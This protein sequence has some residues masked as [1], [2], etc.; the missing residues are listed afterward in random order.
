[1]WIDP[2][3]GAVHGSASLPYRAGRVVAVDSAGT[4]I[5]CGTRQGIA[6][7]AGL[8]P[9]AP[10]PNWRVELGSFIPVGAALAEGVLYVAGSDG[11][12]HVIAESR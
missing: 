8:R 9:G 11:G 4:V 5:L 6:E 2:D 1:V 10:E 12:L 7:C 3:T